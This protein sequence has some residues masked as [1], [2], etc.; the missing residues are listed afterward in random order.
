MNESKYIIQ[1]CML[2]QAGRSKNRHSELHQ[3]ASKFRPSTHVYCQV[4]WVC[5][6]YGLV[7]KTK[8]LHLVLGLLGR[9]YS[10][11]YCIARMM[12]ILCSNTSIKK[13]SFDIKITVQTS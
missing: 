9:S 4:S 6:V 2:G 8:L 10:I 3:P 13:N 12:G 7:D 11:I 5:D 1:T